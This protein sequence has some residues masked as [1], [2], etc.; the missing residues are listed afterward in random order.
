V[1]PFV[2]TINSSGTEAFAVDSQGVFEDFGLSNPSGLLTQNITPSALS[3]NAAPVGVQAIALPSTGTTIFVPETG[4]STVS[5]LELA[6]GPSL[7]QNLSVGTNPV[8]VVGYDEAQ[9]VFAITQ[10]AVAGA[11][12]QVAS[13]ENNPVSI[14]AIIPVG[15]DPVYGVMTLDGNRAFILNRGAATNIGVANKP[16]G[17]V[18]V[19]NVPSNTLDVSSPT[20]SIPDIQ[21][22]DFISGY[23]IAG[24]VITFTG[25][26]PFVAGDTVVLSGFPTGNPL[27]GLTLTVL[28]AGLSS[29]SFEATTTVSASTPSA[30]GEALLSHLVSAHP[31]WA[32]LDTVNSEFVVLNQGDG[33]HPGTLNVISIPLCN[34]GTPV[35]NP[36][37]TATNPV[38]AVGFGTI[39]ATATVGVNPTMVSVL[40]DG[41]RAYVANGGVLPVQTATGT[42]T[43]ASVEGS[44]SVVN[45][46]SGVV[47]ATIPAVST[48]AATAN[49]NTTPTAVY[50]HPNSIAATTGTPTGKVYITSSDNNYMTILET[51]TD[52]VDTHVSL[53]GLGIRVYTTQK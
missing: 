42:Q 29:S 1:S 28:A 45:L 40:A 32:D 13:I 36:N 21:E 37:C 14:S 43:A 35:T 3:A 49:Y 50:G 27:N 19:L 17:S 30:S 18:S 38:D 52:T 4:T 15:I 46:A 11:A 25:G 48:P 53:Q 24:G 9:R 20:I 31:V 41:S 22:T 26:N 33:I 23:S 47:T 5:E 12:G 10:G 39:V 6:S 16:T 2:F 44:V 8:Y 51:D 34:A 7:L